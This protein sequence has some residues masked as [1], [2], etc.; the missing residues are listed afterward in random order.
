MAW[1]I[2]HGSGGGGGGESA[3]ALLFVFL[4]SLTKMASWFLLVRVRRGP[5]Q[6]D[7][8]GINLREYGKA[9]KPS[10][11]GPWAEQEFM[12]GFVYC[13]HRCLEQ[14]AIPFSS[15]DR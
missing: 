13:R 9:Q 1:L 11:A 14:T 5:S 7:S 15:S 8:G 2:S 12:P 6:L 10:L 4:R 3:A